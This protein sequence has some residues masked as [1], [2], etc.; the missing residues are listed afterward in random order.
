[1]SIIVNIIVAAIALA[2]GAYVALQVSK[3][4]ANSAANEILKGAELEGNMLRDKALI[5]VQ[6]LA[7]LLSICLLL[8]SHMTCEQAS[9]IGRRRIT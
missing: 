9:W 2:I 7:S 3:R 6:C 5:T 1:M 8:A 4:N